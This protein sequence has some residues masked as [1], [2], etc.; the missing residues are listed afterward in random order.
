MTELNNWYELINSLYDQ[1]RHGVSVRLPGVS[2]SE[3]W[4][5]ADCDYDDVD[6]FIIDHE[7]IGGG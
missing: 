7:T 1:D 6:R 3:W 2:V 4:N 5:L